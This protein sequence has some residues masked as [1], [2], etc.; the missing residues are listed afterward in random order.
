[1]FHAV[2]HDR[3]LDRHVVRNLIALIEH[4]D[5]QTIAGNNVARVW[6]EPPGKGSNQGGFTF[7]VAA[8]NTN[9]VAIIDAD[10]DPIED[11][12][13]GVFHTKI[14]GAQQMSHCLSLTRASPG[15]EHLS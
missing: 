8:H 9:A 4:P 7:A 10:R 15:A 14:I 5:L 11:D 3:V 13:G 1:V 2:A 6:G 12:S